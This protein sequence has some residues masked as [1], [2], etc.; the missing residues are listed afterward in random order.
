MSFLETIKQQLDKVRPD[1][2]ELEEEIKNNDREALEDSEK[3][4]HEIEELDSEFV[5]LLLSENADEIFDSAISIIKWERDL[6]NFLADFSNRISRIEDTLEKDSGRKFVQ[7]VNEIRS[8]TRDLGF[9]REKIDLNQTS[10]KA[11]FLLD[12][13]GNLEREFEWFE[14]ALATFDREEN[15]L[16]KSRPGKK[17]ELERSEIQKIESTIPRLESRINELKELAEKHQK[18]KLRAE[19]FEFEIKLKPLKSL[20]LKGREKAEM[21]YLISLIEEFDEITA[22]NEGGFTRKEYLRMIASA[23]TIVTGSAYAASA[24][25]YAD[26]GLPVSM[27]GK[28]S[29]EDS[30]DL[31]GLK[32]S[33]SVNGKGDKAEVILDFQNVADNII[34]IEAAVEIPKSWNEKSDDMGFQEVSDMSDQMSKN[35][36]LEPGKE[37]TLKLLISEISGDTRGSIHLE[38]AWGTSKENL[39]RETV[40][41]DMVS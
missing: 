18:S 32:V 5:D 10:E 3:V 8:E 4:L 16:E 11:I 23:S 28:W 2:E 34:N 19:D 17:L 27:R 40:A 6:S 13:F 22:K 25:R 29:Q 36:R 39:R 9:R 41:I 24:T 33:Y 30:L 31:N 35:F 14:E 15:L 1:V 12:N 37:K 26:F 21:E 20:E 7:N 38:I